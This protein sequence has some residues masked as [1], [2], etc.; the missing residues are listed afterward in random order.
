VCYGDRRGTVLAVVAL[1]ETN[2]LHVVLSGAREAVD[3]GAV[4]AVH[5]SNLYASKKLLQ[6][7]CYVM[8]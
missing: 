1:V 8:G 6:L 5:E 7:S 4:V 3:Q 2:G